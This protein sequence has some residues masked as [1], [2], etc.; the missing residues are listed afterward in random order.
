MKWV[1]YMAYLPEKVLEKKLLLF[2]QEDINFGDITGEHVPE[3]DI[4]ANLIAKQHG[5]L[6]GLDFAK[7][8]LKS[9][10]LKI[11]SEKKEKTGTAL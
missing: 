4:T 6:C 7:I 2:L 10:D 9:L 1:K 5:V 8:L 3:K 11:L